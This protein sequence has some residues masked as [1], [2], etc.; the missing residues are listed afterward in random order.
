VKDADMWMNGGYFVLR[1]EIFDYLHEGEELVVQPF[2]RLIAEERLVSIK[3]DGFWSTMDTFKEKQQL[4]DMY[5]RGETPWCVW[6]NPQPKTTPENHR[7]PA[8]V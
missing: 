1:Q 2:Q 7:A 6:K 8:R 4:D 3:Y 5:S